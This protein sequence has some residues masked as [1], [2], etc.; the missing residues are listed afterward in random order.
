MDVDGKLLD[1]LWIEPARPGRHHAAPSA[2]NGISDGRLVARVKPKLI[3]EIGRAERLVAFSIS[4]MAGLAIVAKNLGAA[5]RCLLVIVM[6]RKRKHIFRDIV[7][8]SLRQDAAPAKGRHLGAWA[9]RLGIIGA[10]AVRDGLVDGLDGS[11][12][13][14]G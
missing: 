11:A 8:L 5:R 9:S 10:N 13:Q 3:G 12:P 14:P 7:D 2:A 1:R 4:P 6:L